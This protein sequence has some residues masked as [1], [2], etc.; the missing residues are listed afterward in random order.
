M[1]QGSI[2]DIYDYAELK[3]LSPNRLMDFSSDTNPLGPSNKAKHAIRK[4]VK[5]LGHPPDRRTRYLKRLI[6]ATENIDEK[7]IIIGPDPLYTVSV[8]LKT[9]CPKT[10]LIP[11]P[12]SDAYR[13][14]LKDHN[15][16][17]KPFHL[18]GEKGFAFEAEKFIKKMEG[19]DCI[20]LPNPH[21]MLGNCLPADV[22]RPII[23]RAS[24]MNK[25]LVI[26]E[27]KRDFADTPSPVR[28]IARSGRSIILR[29]F[30]DFHA[31]SG[32]SLGYAI[33]SDKLA[34]DIRGHLGRFSV[35]PLAEAAAVASL[36]DKGYRKRTLAYI[37]EEKRFIKN[38]FAGSDRI[39]CIDTPCSF[40]LLKPGEKI[41]GL[42]DA[43]LQRRIIVVDF[44]DKKGSQYIR[45]PVKKHSWNAR[46]IRALKNISGVD[47]P[48]TK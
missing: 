45:F 24:A 35:N 20:L 31:L 40:L 30:S 8:L 5:H 41:P 47:K 15:V 34:Q 48:C 3:G 39:Q 29:T 27:A 38:S 36:R 28:E 14:L 46:F 10:A 43:F 44:T 13:K 42:R 22:L 33:G 4:K 26:D 23:A 12:I 9:A 2:M 11:S 21:D 18:N 19:A 6:C 17:V 37:K 32:F 1:G 7:N 25:L 16:K